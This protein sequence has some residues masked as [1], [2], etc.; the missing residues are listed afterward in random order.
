MNVRALNSADYQK[1]LYLAA[2]F[3]SIILAPLMAIAALA[4]EVQTILIA[5]ALI[6]ITTLAFFKRELSLYLVILLIP[7]EENFI[8]FHPRYPWAE[9]TD[10]MPFFPWI[11]VASLAGVLM[12]KTAR[13]DEAD[14]ATPVNVFV[15]TF[16]LWAFVGVLWA[17]NLHHTLFQLFILVSNIIMFYLVVVTLRRNEAAHRTAVKILIFCAVILAG[18]SIWSLHFLD[19]NITGSYILTD[20]LTLDYAIKHSDFRAKSLATPNSTAFFLNIAIAFATCLLLRLKGTFKKSFLFILIVF[21]VFGVLETKSKAGV[22]SLLVLGMFFLVAFN[23]LRTKFTRNLLI[24][25]AVIV[26]LFVLQTIGQSRTPRILASEEMSFT[27]RLQIWERGLH[28]FIA[29]AP[30]WGLGVGG[31]RYYRDPMPHGHSIYFSTLFDF[32]IV[33]ILSLAGLIIALI[34]RFLK[35]IP[36]QKTYAQMMLVASAGSLLVVLVHGLVDFSY[37]DYV[38]WWTLGMATGTILLVEDERRP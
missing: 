21:L 36:Y 28:S 29:K 1:R 33:G 17:P 30:G 11:A 37:L 18:L 6:T 13:I 5:L 8:G 4:W 10:L 23:A 9:S 2:L 22:G 20:G 34:A 14:F 16:L 3:A 32:G 12:R 19:K 38:V 31:L 24:F 7:I 35:F 26:V 27:A 25:L 15:L